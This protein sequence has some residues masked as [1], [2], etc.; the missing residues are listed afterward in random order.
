[1]I[2]ESPPYY[3]HYYTGTCIRYQINICRDIN[4]N[5]C[6]LAE[7]FTWYTVPAGVLNHHESW[8]QRTAASTEI[9]R[10]SG[11][12]LTRVCSIIQVNAFAFGGT[13]DDGMGQAKHKGGEVEKGGAIIK[14]RQGRS[15]TKLLRGANTDTITETD[16]FT[17]HRNCCSLAPVK[18][19]TQDWRKNIVTHMYVG[20]I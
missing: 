10:P 3:G 1:M 11:P 15:K 5:I 7:G 20:E 12:S 4:I 19:K 17:P 2:L 6:T 8:E 18:K 16:T 9:R 14:E 13:L